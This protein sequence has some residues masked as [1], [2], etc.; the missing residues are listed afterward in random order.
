MS[1]SL[2]LFYPKDAPLANPL[3]LFLLVL[4]MST[5]DDESCV[6]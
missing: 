4:S 5:V 1:D 6:R 2:R 3:A